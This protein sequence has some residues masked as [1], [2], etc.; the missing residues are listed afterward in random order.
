MKAV[1][2]NGGKPLLEHCHAQIQSVDQISI[3][4][5]RGKRKL[6]PRS[7]KLQ[8][9]YHKTNSQIT[10]LIKLLISLI[11]SRAMS[12]PLACQL[13]GQHWVQGQ[14]RKNKARSSQ[15]KLWKKQKTQDKPRDNVKTDNRTEDTST[16]NS[17]NRQPA[18]REINPSHVVSSDDEVNNAEKVWFLRNV[19]HIRQ[20]SQLSI[21]LVWQLLEQGQD[22]AQVIVDRAR[23]STLFK[24][25]LKIHPGSTNKL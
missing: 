8:S 10:V 16:T 1:C 2:R 14:P 6:Q 5:G 7:H 18:R 24:A 12:I 13:S 15:S 11:K 17:S 25:Q 9:V 4:W 22:Q 23:T 21:P 3:N 19:S 20:L